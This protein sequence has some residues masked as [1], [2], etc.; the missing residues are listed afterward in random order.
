VIEVAQTYACYFCGGSGEVEGETC[1]RCNGSGRLICDWIQLGMV[2]RDA[3]SLKLDAIVA[4][5]ASQREDLTNA[6]TQIWN[7]VKDL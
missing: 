5:Q 3:L 6:L 4:E 1:P 2:E 7:K